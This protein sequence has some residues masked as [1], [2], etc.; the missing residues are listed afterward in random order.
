MYTQGF[1]EVLT[2]IMTANIAFADIPTASAILDA[3]NYTFQAVTF[4][5]DAAGYTRHAHVVSSTNYINGDSASGA[6]AYDN[7]RLL[8]VNYGSDVANGASSYVVTSTYLQYSSTYNSVPNDPSPLDRRL[9]RGSTSAT[10]LSNYQYASAIVDLGH[11]AN[12]AIDAQLSAIWNKVGG[13]GPSSNSDYYFMDNTSSFAFSGQVSSFFNANSLM[14]KYGYL[15]VSPLSGL[16]SALSSLG[17]PTSGSAFSEGALVFSSTDLNPG[18]GISNL[19]VRLKDGDAASLALFGGLHH[20][21]VWCLDLKQMLRD[22]LTPPF[23]WD[24]LNNT[25]KYRLVSKVTFWDNLLT[26]EDNGTDAGIEM[27]A[28]P[29]ASDFTFGGPVFLLK[30]NF[31]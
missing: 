3:S 9:E 4:G 15:T 27:L 13:F 22:G 2:D 5:K 10:H 6:S 20:I 25:R 11:Y 17:N 12:P 29:T 14:D 26:H 16:G 24:A 30:F 31:T 1:G 8:V 7:G 23:S 28:N 18:V 19:A 21:G